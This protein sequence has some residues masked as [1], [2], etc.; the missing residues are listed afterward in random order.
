[1][2]FFSDAD[3]PELQRSLGKSFWLRKV[4]TSSQRALNAGPR[5]ESQ[6]SY[7]DQSAGCL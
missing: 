3:F 1:M 5:A 4:G 2:K 7:P 6:K